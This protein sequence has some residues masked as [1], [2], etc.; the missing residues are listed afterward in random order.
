[1]THLMQIE[2]LVF[3][4]LTAPLCLYVTWTDLSQMRIPN[5]SVLILIAIFAVAGLF[6]L[7]LEVYAMRW[8]WALGVLVVGFLMSTIGPIAIGAGDAKFAAALSLF[9][10]KGDGL[11]FLVLFAGV[12]LVSWLVHRIAGKITLIRKATATWASWEAGKLFPMGVALAGTLILYLAL[13][14]AQI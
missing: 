1:M 12:L 5:V 13:G 14:V 6:L 10:A 9:I 7:P 2:A 4:I 3:L 11:Q 8:V